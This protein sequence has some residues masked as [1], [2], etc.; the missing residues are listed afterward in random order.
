MVPSDKDKASMNACA[1][2]RQLEDKEAV[3]I[4]QPVPV[5]RGFLARRLKVAPGT[6]EN[7]RRGRV[8]EP[9]ASLVEK[10]KG[11]LIRELE[12]EIQALSHEVEILRRSGCRPDEKQ[13]LEAETLLAKAKEILR[14]SG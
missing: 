3:R 7:M 5:A 10:I 1:W 6:L 2:V 14:G 9:R 13:I 11:A 8:K 4:G 12:S